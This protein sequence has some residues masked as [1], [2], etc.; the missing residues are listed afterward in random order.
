MIAQ[1]VT[2]ATSLASNWM[3]NK[4]EESAA[5]HQAK[6]QVIQNQASWEKLMASREQLILERRMVHYFIK[7]S[8]CRYGLGDQHG[9]PGGHRTNRNRV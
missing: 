8:D 3:S 6:L 1:L 2:A 9:R 4:R 5:K 7:R